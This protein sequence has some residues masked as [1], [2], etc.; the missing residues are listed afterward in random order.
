MLL[1]CTVVSAAEIDSVTLASLPDEIRQ[2]F[3]KSAQAKRYQLSAHINPFYLH[4]DFDGDGRADTALLIKE[5]SSSKN[6]MAIYHGK[7]HRF[8]IVGA[9]E[10][11]GN[12]SDDF[13]G[14]DAWQVYQRGPVSKGADGKPP[15][16]LRGDALLVIKTESASALIYWNGKRYAWYQQ[17]D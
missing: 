8:S 11:W 15:P 17:G 10:D 9:G 7:S 4:G 2:A 5:K 13:P 3:E 14:M 12:G 16:K 6:G 1:R